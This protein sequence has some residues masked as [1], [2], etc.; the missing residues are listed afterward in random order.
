MNFKTYLKEKDNSSV[1]IIDFMQQYQIPISPKFFEELYPKQKE[2]YC[3]MALEP[4]RLASLF[5]RQKRKNQLSTFTKFN[6]TS[7]FWGAEDLE[8]TD[9]Y[10]TLV[11]VLKGKASLKGNQDLWTEY[12]KGGRRWV[13][14]RFLYSDTWDNIQQEIKDEF[15][16]ELPT[17]VD[18]QIITQD[19][20]GM[21][22]NISEILFKHPHLKRK[23]IKL[24]FDIAYAALKKNKKDLEKENLQMQAGKHYNEVLCHSYTVERI[25]VITSDLEITKEILDDLPISKTIDFDINT[26]NGVAKELRKYQK[27]ND[28][29]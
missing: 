19:R 12:E 21:V 4:R 15:K 6:N 23:V 11:A 16:K 29:N 7:I 27:M 8:W 3:F 18:K 25:F 10:H 13:D 24:Y 26:E 22:T 5:K 2:Q 17:L 9:K 14:V 28:K 20:G 1:K